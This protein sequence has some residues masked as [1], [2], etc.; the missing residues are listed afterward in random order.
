MPA[1]QIWTPEGPVS[2]ERAVEEVKAADMMVIAQMADVCRR[3][4]IALVCPA[5]DASFE[6]RNGTVDSTWSIACKCRELRAAMGS[7][8]PA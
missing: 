4:R 7:G 1:P 8:R 5:C 2:V 6:G 3:H